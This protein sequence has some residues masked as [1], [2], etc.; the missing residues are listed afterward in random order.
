M[1]ES[2]AGQASA[3]GRTVMRAVG[4]IAVVSL[5]AVGIALCIAT[6]SRAAPPSFFEV[7]FQQPGTIDCSVFNPAWAFSDNFVDFFHVEGADYFDASGNLT[8]EVLH[9]QQTSNDVN[10]LTSFTLR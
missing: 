2:G 1:R 9:V 4:R 3:S 5:A 7:D 6:A 10:S 8:R